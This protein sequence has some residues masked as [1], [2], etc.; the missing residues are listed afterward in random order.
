MQRALALT[1][2]CIFGLPLASPLLAMTSG[3]DPESR[4]PACCR[5]AGAHHCTMSP[6]ELDTVAHG[7]NV[8]TVRST[9]PLFP[10]VTLNLGSHTLAINTASAPSIHLRTTAMQTQQA[11]VSARVAEAGARHKRG[12]PAVRPS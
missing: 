2:L 3:N 8:T 1:L 6:E 10:H 7:Q 12:P 4:L 5:R 11:E 9:C